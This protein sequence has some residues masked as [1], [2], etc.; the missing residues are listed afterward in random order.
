MMVIPGNSTTA[1]HAR[2]SARGPAFGAGLDFAF[3]PRLSLFL[4]SNFGFIFPDNAV[5]GFNPGGDA[6]TTS[7]DD[8][9][10]DVLGH[11]GGGLKFNFRGVGTKADIQ[12]LQCP[13]E[14]T[15]GETGSFMVMTNADATQPVTTT[16][17]F[18]D[19]STRWAWRWA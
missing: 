1:R 13:A 11:Y 8:V 16:W 18:G 5:D 4:E 17:N 9:E 3:S 7:G 19:T 15:V 6:G 2:R 14:L 12:S 10:F